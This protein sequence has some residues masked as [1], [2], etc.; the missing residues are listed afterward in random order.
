MARSSL[1]RQAATPEAI[2]AWRE[3]R[4]L[5]VRELARLLTVT[6]P[7]ILRWETGAAPIPGWLPLAL[8][9]LDRRLRRQEA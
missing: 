5:G 2:R 4:R 6:H 7:T 1:L 3:Q 8:A 9:E